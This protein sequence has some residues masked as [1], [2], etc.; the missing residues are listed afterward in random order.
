MNKKSIKNYKNKIIKKFK[1]KKIFIKQKAFFLDRDGVINKLLKNDYV[2]NIEE[3]IFLPGVFRSISYLNRQNFKVIIITNQACVGK[4]IITENKLNYIHKFMINEIKKNNGFI[5][6]IFYSCYYKNSKLEKYK[7][8]FYDRKPNP[9]MFKKAFKKWNIDIKKSYFIGDS[10]TDKK[11]AK[12]IN[13]K[14]Y[15]KEKGSLFLQIKKI[16]KD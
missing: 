16:L 8:N 12:K 13:L 6:D 1:K 15:Y 4:S 9:G 7:K 14:F 3:F 2:K 10:I 5:D 11:V